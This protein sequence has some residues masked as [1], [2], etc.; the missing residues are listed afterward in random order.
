MLD[1]LPTGAAPLHRATEDR[2]LA[3]VCAGIA[4]RSG[5]PAGQVRLAFAALTA[6]L[7]LG[8]LLYV[9]AVLVLPRG[10]S[11]ESPPLVRALAGV[12]LVLAASLGLGVLAAGAVA[13]TLFG[14]GGVVFGVSAAFL[15]GALVAWPSVRPAWV[16]LP[17]VAVAA[18]AVAAA[19]SGVRIAR[20]TGVQ[21]KTPTTPGQVPAGGYVAGVGDLLVDLRQLEAAPGTSVPVRV[22]AG[23]GLTVVALPHDRCVNVDVRWGTGTGAVARETGAALELFGREQGP[24]GRRTRLS[25]DP[26]APWVRID[27]ASALGGDLVVR[28]YPAATGPLFEP[29]WPQNVQP[30][31][32]PVTAL[33]ATS[34]SARLRRDRHALTRRQ[35]FTRTLERL[36]RGACAA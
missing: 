14:L 36:E 5:V 25:S 2:V 33:T 15:A 16:L 21:V 23:T 3:G 20:Q 13:A 10:E 19:A 9:A 31:A 29:S 28:D 7:G 30:P 8:A 34:E 35:A 26:R 11:A 12:G 4:A 6:V 27:F 24:R 17:L 18:P 32:E 1:Q 22:R